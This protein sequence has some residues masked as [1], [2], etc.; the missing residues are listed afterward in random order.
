MSEPLLMNI[1]ERLLLNFLVKYFAVI[2]ITCPKPIKSFSGYYDGSYPEKLML[3][4]N[5]FYHCMGV[6][7]DDKQTE[8][9][10]LH[11][12]GVAVLA[13]KLLHRNLH[14][15]FIYKNSFL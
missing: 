9:Q 11:L 13:M 14:I 1:C 2:I 12:E 6:H 4:M 5:L 15:S 3:I 8:A 7:A 10:N